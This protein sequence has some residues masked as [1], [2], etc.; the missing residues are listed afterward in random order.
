MAT[1]TDVL[2]G[3]MTADPSGGWLQ[4]V[5]QQ[6]EGVHW[7]ALRNPG[8]ITS[9]PDTRTVELVDGPMTLPCVI[10]T[11]TLMV[12]FEDARDGALPTGTAADPRRHHVSRAIEALRTLAQARAR[13]QGLET[14]PLFGIIVVGGD[15]VPEPHRTTILEG[16]PHIEREQA[17]DLYANYWGRIGAEALLPFLPSSAATAISRHATTRK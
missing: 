15:D 13:A 4:R 7:G 5:Y 14:D 1:L 12:A 16:L 8:T 9:G 11:D 3:V 6:L 10:E 17:E 2:Q